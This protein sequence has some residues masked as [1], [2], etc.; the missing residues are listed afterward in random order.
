MLDGR[1]S[2]LMLGLVGDMFLMEIIERGKK[3]DA[4][5]SCRCVFDEAHI[6]KKAIGC[7]VS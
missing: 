3:F 6:E 4:A 5:S 1:A 2:R 7:C